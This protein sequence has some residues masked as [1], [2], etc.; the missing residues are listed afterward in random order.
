MLKVTET[1]T[2]NVIDQTQKSQ[3]LYIAQVYVLYY[4]NDVN[5]KI[6]CV[7]WESGCSQ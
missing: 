2:T 7:Y 6:Q 5:I 1:L 4:Y 3:R